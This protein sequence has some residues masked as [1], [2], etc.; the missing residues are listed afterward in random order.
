LPI[1]VETPAEPLI[2]F[3]APEAAMF[4]AAAWDSPPTVGG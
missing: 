1:I 3:D 4:P 2:G